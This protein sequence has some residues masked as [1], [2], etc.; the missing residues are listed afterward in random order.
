MCDLLRLYEWGKRRGTRIQR[1]PSEC[2]SR[3]GR[4]VLVNVATGFTVAAVTVDATEVG[5]STLIGGH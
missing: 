4:L 5:A 2:L 3:R 1:N